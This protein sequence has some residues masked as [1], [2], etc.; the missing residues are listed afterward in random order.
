MTGI[1][2]L[3]LQC[4]K[5]IVF[6]TKHLDRLRR[7]IAY[8]EKAK[9]LFLKLNI[10]DDILEFTELEHLNNYNGYLTISMLDLSV[11]LKNLI[12]AKTDW[13]KIFFIKNS[14]L[15]IHE[16]LNKLKPSKSKN[17]IEESIKNLYPSLKDRFTELMSEVDAFKKRPEYK[18]IEDTR[19]YTAGHIEK[20]LKKYYDT[21]LD[22]DGETAGQNIK[23]FLKI[24]GKALNLTKDY[25]ALAHETQLKKSK[26]TE[27]KVAS[28]LEKIKSLTEK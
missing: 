19:H 2:S 25:A 13:E 27:A 6:Y 24:T 1:D 11:N 21:I 16:T 12:L 7:N 9:K 10:N 4:N 20:S 14:Y 28:A 15:I 3:F 26:E 8:Q 18:K 5:N 23:E 22:L 17:F